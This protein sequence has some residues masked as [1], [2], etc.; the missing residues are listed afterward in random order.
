VRDADSVPLRVQV[1][2]DAYGRVP[3]E[4][5]KHG[6]VSVDRMRVELR[7]ERLKLGNW[8]D[9]R[10]VGDGVVEL[11]IHHGQGYRVYVGRRDFQTIVL[12]CGGSKSTQ[13][14]DIE[15]A[16]AR[17]SDFRRRSREALD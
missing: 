12:I 4:S 11:R 10:S 16:Q 6:L 5:W 9:W 1:Y 15:R 17:W 2:A 13:Q 14:K 3:F 7:I 8:G